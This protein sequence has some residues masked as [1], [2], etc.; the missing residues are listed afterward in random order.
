[1]DWETILLSQRGFLQQVLSQW[2]QVRIRPLLEGSRP[3]LIVQVSIAWP[4]LHQKNQPNHIQRPC[5]TTPDPSPDPA[6][7]LPGWLYRSSAA[8]GHALEPPSSVLEFR[9]QTG[10]WPQH[11]PVLRQLLFPPLVL[12][13][14]R[15]QPSQVA[16]GQSA[17]SIDLR[18]V[19]NSQK[20][21][22]VEV[23][24]SN[25]IFQTVCP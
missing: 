18:P 5:R 16:W 17:G 11:R 9:R 4:W 15:W 8:A 19:I 10:V 13:L 20:K 1:M 24:L 7:T 14:L 25:K 3:F 23:P 21:P 2:Y 6:L 22:A 12:F